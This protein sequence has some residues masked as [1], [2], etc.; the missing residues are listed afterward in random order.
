MK[1]RRNRSGWCPILSWLVL[2]GVTHGQTITTYEMTVPDPFADADR[3]G[4]VDQMD[5]AAWQRCLTGLTLPVTDFG[6]PVNC[7]CFDRN[8]DGHVSVGPDFP[9]FA[10][11][12][13]GAG[14][15]AAITCDD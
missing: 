15:P 7:G 4:D 1:R 13:S 9:D 2:A 11:C 10:D 6:P 14:V 12:A 5:F 3:D 8:G